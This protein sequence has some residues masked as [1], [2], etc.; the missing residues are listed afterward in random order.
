MGSSVFGSLLQCNRLTSVRRAKTASF[1]SP[2]PLGDFKAMLLRKH[3][4]I[5]FCDVLRWRTVDFSQSQIG[6]SDL[7]I[8]KVHDPTSIQNQLGQYK[9]TLSIRLR[10]GLKGNTAA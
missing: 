5:V 9:N 10:V 2:S 6:I 1:L 8:P 3:L 7:L 4:L